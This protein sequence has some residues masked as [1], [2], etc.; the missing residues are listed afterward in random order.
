[1]LQ[2]GKVYLLVSAF[3]FFCIALMGFY[4]FKRPLYN[5]DMLP[6]ENLILKLDGFNAKE[7]HS[8]TY[9][10]TRENIPEEYFRQLTDTN[11]AYRSRMMKDAAAF[12]DELP[13]Y[14]VKPLYIGFSYLFYKAGTPLPQATKVP[15]IISYLL[16]GLLLFYWL[17]RYVPLPITFLVALLLM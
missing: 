8:Q 3:Y 10:L 7:A 17:R 4:C 16:I 2:K 6:Y 11:H 5:W 14:I 12:G 1:M 15:A 9:Q 13:F